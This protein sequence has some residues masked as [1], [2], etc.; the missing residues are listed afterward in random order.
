MKFIV[1]TTKMSGKQRHT[2]V[3]A[4]NMQEAINFA[5]CDFALDC[6]KFKKRTRN[7]VVTLTK[8]TLNGEKPK[9]KP[10][11]T[12]DI[13]IR[14]ADYYDA[15]EMNTPIKLTSSFDEL[16]HTLEMMPQP[17]QATIHNKVVARF[18]Y[19]LEDTPYNVRMTTTFHGNSI[20]LTFTECNNDEA[21]PCVFVGTNI[22]ACV[23]QAKMAYNRKF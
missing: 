15:Y 7:G 6:V 19:N 12:K 23:N 11:R 18:R 13:V 16:Q 17:C 14:P 21:I 8:T 22:D 4:D 1:T 3:D 20:V 9:Y 5:T 2:V 10:S